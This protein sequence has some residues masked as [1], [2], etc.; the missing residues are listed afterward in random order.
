[1]NEQEANQAAVEAAEYWADMG[2]VEYRVTDVPITDALDWGKSRPSLSHVSMDEKGQVSLRHGNEDGPMYAESVLKHGNI[3][4]LPDRQY[5][6]RL[7]ADDVALILR[8][9]ES[10]KKLLAKLEQVERL[11]GRLYDRT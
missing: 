9:E 11:T 5:P 10:N 4:I 6:L 8:L 2:P 1:V 7:H 3:Q